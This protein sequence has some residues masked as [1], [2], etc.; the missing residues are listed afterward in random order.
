PRQR[1]LR[2]G[3]RRRRGRV[4]LERAA[5]PAGAGGAAPRG[6]GAG[7]VDDRPADASVLWLRAPPPR[8]AVL[9]GRRQA[10]SLDRESISAARTCRSLRAVAAWSANGSSLS[11]S[12]QRSTAIVKASIPTSA[13]SRAVSSSAPRSRRLALIDLAIRACLSSPRSCS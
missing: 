8:P 10:E 3:A 9:T 12:I 2:G 11:A 5:R 13:P 6:D 7:P 4:P 1:R